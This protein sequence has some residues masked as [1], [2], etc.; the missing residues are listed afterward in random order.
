MWRTK[1]STLTL[2][3]SLKIS[4]FWRPAGTWGFLPPSS[5]GASPSHPWLWLDVEVLK[6]NLNNKIETRNKIVSRNRCSYW[7]CFSVSFTWLSDS[8]NSHSRWA[9]PAPNKNVTCLCGCIFNSWFCISQCGLQLKILPN[10]HLTSFDVFA[11]NDLW[12]WSVRPCWTDCL[13]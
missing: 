2:S 9:V 8:F 4:P 1:E 6:L 3:L 13:C 12:M 11:T 5:F 7:N 10:Q